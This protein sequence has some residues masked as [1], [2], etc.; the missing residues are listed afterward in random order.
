MIAPL[1]AGMARG[2]LFC[3]VTEHVIILVVAIDPSRQPFVFTDD[4][5]ASLVRL[6]TI[7]AVRFSWGALHL[8]RALEGELAGKT[9]DWNGWCKKNPEYVYLR[10]F[11]ALVQSPQARCSDL[12]N[13]RRSLYLQGFA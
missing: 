11:K 2:L 1:C 5:I 8:Y 7:L 9:Y 4:A 3:W 6:C 12:W 13:T 10:I